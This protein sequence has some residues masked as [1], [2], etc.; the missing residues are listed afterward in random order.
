MV[1]LKKVNPLT[2]TLCSLH[3]LCIDSGANKVE[4]MPIDNAHHITHIVNPSNQRLC[5]GKYN[6]Y[7]VK[8]DTTGQPVD[9]LH[10]K[11]NLTMTLITGERRSVH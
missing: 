7:V 6:Q 10:L 8:I 5:T 11:K 1:T 2:M 4:I 9:I 3:N